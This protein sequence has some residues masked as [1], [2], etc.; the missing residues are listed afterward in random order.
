MTYLAYTETIEKPEPNEMIR[1]VDRHPIRDIAKPLTQVD[2]RS[3][4]IR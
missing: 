4:G 2:Q 1:N 3:Q